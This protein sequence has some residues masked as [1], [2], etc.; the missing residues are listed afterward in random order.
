MT[1]EKRIR[2]LHN[3]AFFSVVPEGD[4]VVLAEAMHEEM[5]G[6]GELVFEYG[7]RADRVYVVA[8]GELMAVVPGKEGTARQIG[9][10]DLVGEYGL[11]EHGARS[12]TVTCQSAVTLLS[13]DYTRF[14]E[15]LVTF[16]EATLSILGR[17]VR[18]LLVLEEKSR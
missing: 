17:T 9:P 13:M 1:L 7:D 14:R 16:P 3:C 6:D 18:R 12:A 8:E 2:T 10:G 15:F 11:F 5:F 4:L